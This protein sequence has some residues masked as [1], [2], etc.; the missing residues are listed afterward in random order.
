M[1]LGVLL[2][3]EWGEVLQNK[4]IRKRTAPVFSS[5][6]DMETFKEF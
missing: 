5:D 4:T 2:L 6:L 1:D 3:F